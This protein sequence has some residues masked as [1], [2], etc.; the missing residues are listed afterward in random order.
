MYTGLIAGAA[1]LIDY[2]LT[3]AVS[4]SAGVAALT[5]AFHALSPS[6]VFMGTGLVALIGVANLRGIRE[7]ER[8][9]AVWSYLFIAGYAVLMPY[10]FAGHVMAGAPPAPAPPPPVTH[11]AS[12][13]GLFLLLRAFSSGAVALTAIEAVSDGVTAFKPP[14]VKNAQTAL[15]ALGAIMV[16]RRD[17]GARRESRHRPAGRGVVSQL[18]RRVFG[19]GL[20]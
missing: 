9:F 16:V 8:V 7:S 17:H 6:R 19:G 2:T 12:G 5:S 15:M 14:E 1:L 11:A 4:V 18:A 20:F 3:V 10:G 13:L